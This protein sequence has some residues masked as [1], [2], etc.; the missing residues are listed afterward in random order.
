[1]TVGGLGALAGAVYKPVADTVPQLAPEQP[2]PAT[3][4]VTP[5]IE[6]PVTVAVN[7][8]VPPIG[9]CAEVGDTLTTIGATSVTVAMLDLVGSALEVA[10]TK[11][12]AGLGKVAGAV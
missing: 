3:L 11:T 4:Q 8:A 1:V 10:V 2:G 9:T 6:V 5:V 12:I 7:C